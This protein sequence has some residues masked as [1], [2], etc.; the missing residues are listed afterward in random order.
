ML[1]KESTL[2]ILYGQ[3]AASSFPTIRENGDCVPPR[4]LLHARW[5]RT[6]KFGRSV[7]VHVL[8]YA[9]TI[10]TRCLMARSVATP[11][12]IKSFYRMASAKLTEVEVQIYTLLSRL[13]NFAKNR[14][15][16]TWLT[17]KVLANRGRTVKDALKWRFQ[18]DLV[19][20]H[21]WRSLMNDTRAKRDICVITYKISQQR[22]KFLNQDRSLKRTMN[23]QV[24]WFLLRNNCTLLNL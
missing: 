13:H 17:R 5:K 22:V 1:I 23:D 18:F 21:R 11:R 10:C 14:Y 4:W 6:I 19:C 16:Y 12:V 3:V 24:K 2:Y 8:L 9:L 15:L 20:S 7:I